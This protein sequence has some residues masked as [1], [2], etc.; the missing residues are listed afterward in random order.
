MHNCKCDYE[1]KYCEV[2][3]KVYC[4]KCKDEWS[5]EDTIT[6]SD[7]PNTW[8]KYTSSGIVKNLVYHTH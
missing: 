6:I 8:A 7:V 3:G 1:L 2:C 4:L 5:K